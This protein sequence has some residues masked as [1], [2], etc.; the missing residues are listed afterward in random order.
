MDGPIQ[1]NFAGIG[2]VESRPI[3]TG[4]YMAHGCR[5]AF[6][7]HRSVPGKTKEH[8]VCHASEILCVGS[9]FVLVAR[10]AKRI[11]SVGKLL[12]LLNV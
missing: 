12:T 10:T 2:G 9:G 8:S 1:L 5:L 3:G 7:H 4:L 11:V 6:A